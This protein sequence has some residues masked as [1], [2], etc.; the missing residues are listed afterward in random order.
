MIGYN[1]VTAIGI[2]IICEKE[3]GAGQSHIAV[4]DMTDVTVT[5][6][7]TVVEIV[8]VRDIGMIETD[9]GIHTT[10]LIFVYLP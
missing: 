6:V 8:T 1:P 10:N 2:G 7:E 4:I 3:R 9:I 5:D